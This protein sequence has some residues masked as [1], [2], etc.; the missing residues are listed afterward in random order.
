[1][2]LLMHSISCAWSLLNHSRREHTSPFG[3]GRTRCTFSYDFL[4]RINDVRIFSATSEAPWRIKGQGR[5]HVGLH[6]DQ[7]S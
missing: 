5:S 2:T 3:L 7:S 6:D 1:M 4:A